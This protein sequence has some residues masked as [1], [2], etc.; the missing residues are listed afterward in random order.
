MLDLGPDSYVFAYAKEGAVDLLAVDGATASDSDVNDNDAREKAATDLLDDLAALFQFA[1]YDVWR[2]PERSA[3]RGAE[4]MCWSVTDRYS[5]L[6][7]AFTLNGKGRLFFRNVDAGTDWQRLALVFT[8]DQVNKTWLGCHLPGENGPVRDTTK[9]G[10]PFVRQSALEE[11]TEF[12][13]TTFKKW[14]PRRT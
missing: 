4:R 10:A 14:H 9:P 13:L 11:L 7:I 8:W 6:P 1:G 2:G 12:V 5:H 3:I